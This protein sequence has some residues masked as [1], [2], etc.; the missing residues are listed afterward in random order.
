MAIPDPTKPAPV[1]YD[2]NIEE[3]VQPAIRDP[4]HVN[5]RAEALGGHTI[6]P[7]MPQHQPL[8]RTTFHQFTQGT[9]ERT[10]AARSSSSDFD[11]FTGRPL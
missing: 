7:R 10:P 5:G 9:P 2:Y 8:F 1:P 3:P 4:R 6:E 11:L